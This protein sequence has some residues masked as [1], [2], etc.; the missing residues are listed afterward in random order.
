LEAA[1]QSARALPNPELEVKL[2]ELE[3]RFETALRS[4]KAAAP[5]RF[6]RR[7][8]DEMRLLKLAA[9]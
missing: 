7:A 6:Q 2:K 3:G 9:A 4:A 1:Y 5:T 8:E